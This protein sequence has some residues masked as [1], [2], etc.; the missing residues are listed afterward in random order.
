MTK[1]EGR[2]SK[3]M[4]TCMLTVAYPDRTWSP[5]LFT[6]GFSYLPAPWS[7]RAETHLVFLD[8]V[9]RR[10]SLFVN[11]NK[12]EIMNN[13]ARRVFFCGYDLNMWLISCTNSAAAV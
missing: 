1:D 7:G 4:K 11:N 12:K 3:Y 5:I 8:R 6:T 2:L 9:R 13:K 10:I